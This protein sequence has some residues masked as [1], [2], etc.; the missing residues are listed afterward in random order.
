[1]FTR[2]NFFDDYRSVGLSPL[3]RLVGLDFDASFVSATIEQDLRRG[4]GAE[5]GYEHEKQD[6]PR[7]PPRDFD[8]NYDVDRNFQPRVDSQ[9][10]DWDRVHGTIG[11]ARPR[12]ARA[13]VR[14]DA[15]HRYDTYFGYLDRHQT[16]VTPEIHIQ[17]A[18]RLEIGA[19]LSYLHNRYPNAHL[20]L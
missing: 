6:F 13:A 11:W 20:D 3:T 19:S 14:I 15:S 10:F 5:V 7:R 16:L 17:A 12:R 4:F 9:Q 8:G 2:R 1:Q 18:D